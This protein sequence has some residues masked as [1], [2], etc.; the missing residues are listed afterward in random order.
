MV[1]SSSAK[2]DFFNTVDA[3]ASDQNESRATKELY[4]ALVAHRKELS[5]EHALPEEDKQLSEE[6]H[7]AA[8]RRSA[9]ITAYNATSGRQAA[10]AGKPIPPW[11]IALWA[12]AIIGA[13][14]A[15]IL[16]E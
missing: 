7:R 10:T 4:D 16:W 6:L 8:A 13:I 9:E 11:L 15:V 14:L 12:V 3:E 2:Q 5:G 1:E